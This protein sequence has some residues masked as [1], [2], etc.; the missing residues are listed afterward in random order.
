M[1]EREKD[2]KGRKMES[3]EAK[4][5]RELKLWMRNTQGGVERDNR[6]RREEERE[7]EREEG[8]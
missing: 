8:K 1:R 4:G 7:G 3:R 6:E 5:L 2:D